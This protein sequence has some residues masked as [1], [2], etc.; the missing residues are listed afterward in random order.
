MYASPQ[1]EG[2]N[3]NQT[4]PQK[5]AF[6]TKETVITRVKS[7]ASQACRNLTSRGVHLCSLMCA[8]RC[9]CPLKLHSPLSGFSSQRAHLEMRFK[10]AI[11]VEL[12]GGRRHRSDRGIVLCPN[13]NSKLGVWC[14]AGAGKQKDAA[15]ASNC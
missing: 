15:A 8:H 12:C 9:L 13:H 5:A 11:S 2:E 4:P 6:G 3:L 1:M 7:K 10:T 14:G